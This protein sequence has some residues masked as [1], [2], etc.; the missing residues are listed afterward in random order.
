LRA[1]RQLPRYASL[2]AIAVT[3]LTREKDIAMA[4]EAGFDAHIGKPMSVERLTEIIRDRLP[5]R[6]ER[7]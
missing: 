5:A 6:Q 2:P 3:G 7:V 1:A 4:R